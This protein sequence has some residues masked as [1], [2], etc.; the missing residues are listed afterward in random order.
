M[1]VRAILFAGLFLASVCR[2]DIAPA[3]VPNFA[4]GVP[5]AGGHGRIGTTTGDF[6]IAFALP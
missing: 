6:I 2:Q 1:P 4:Y 3:I 5:G